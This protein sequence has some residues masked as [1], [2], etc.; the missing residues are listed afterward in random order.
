MV[1][2]TVQDSVGVSF[3]PCA[4][5]I[6]AEP[7]IEQFFGLVC[8]TIS[9][10]KL[11]P[12]PE[13][14]ADFQLPKRYQRDTQTEAQLAAREER[15]EK[16]QKAKEYRHSIAKEREEKPVRIARVLPADD[17]EANG[18]LT[19]TEK[20]RQLAEI[21]R[22]TKPIAI[23]AVPPEKPQGPRN[24]RTNSHRRMN[25]DDTERTRISTLSPDPEAG[26]DLGDEEDPNLV[27]WYGPG[28]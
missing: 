14:R 8:H 9:G 10:G 25:S 19:A 6:I 28:K 3:L 12:F 23:A 17:P 5:N 16:Q 21:D 2:G 1:R 13:E 26:L 27:D 15:L 24:R 11:F 20:Q 22:S 18:D 4:F 7:D